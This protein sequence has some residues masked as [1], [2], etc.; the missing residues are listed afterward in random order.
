MALIPL[1]GTAKAR[2]SLA[3]TPRSTVRY[4]ISKD[5]TFTQAV[6]ELPIIQDK[7]DNLGRELMP[8][9]SAVRTAQSMGVPL[10]E[11]RIPEEI[12]AKWETRE[13]LKEE[14]DRILAVMLKGDA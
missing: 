10:T 14:R 5:Y 2:V 7:I 6:A 11:I 3:G 9:I 4:V 12:H 8:A 13:Q 1:S